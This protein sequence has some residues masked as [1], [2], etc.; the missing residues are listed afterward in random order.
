MQN[1]VELSKNFVVQR[2]VLA[3][4]KALVITDLVNNIATSGKK[5]LVVENLDEFF[6][7]SNLI[8]A[9]NKGD[10]EMLTIVAEKQGIEISA[11]DLDLINAFGA[12]KKKFLD[13]ANEKLP[14]YAF[15]AIPEGWTVT[16]NLNI[17]KRS[18]SR[19]KG[20]T[21]Y[22]I[23]VKTLER[24][25]KVAS[26]VWNGDTDPGL[27]RVNSISAG[28]YNRDALIKPATVEI[29]CQTIMRF[30]LEQ[31]ALHMGWTFPEVVKN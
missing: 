26:L 8:N 13:L 20:E 19:R 21:G 22:S 28:G 24:V 12:L 9:V 31:V 30:E 29:G 23:G 15:A 25:W 17:D 10:T 1:V 6:G 27:R 11:Y 7:V 14:P 5:M 2:S 4:G 16:E 3:S 18:V